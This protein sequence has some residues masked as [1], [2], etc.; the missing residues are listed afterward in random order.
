MDNIINTAKRIFRGTQGTFLG[1]IVLTVFFSLAS[2]YFFQARNF[3]NILEKLSKEHNRKIYPIQTGYSDAGPDLGAD[4]L[5]L[6]KAP[7]IAIFKN[8]NL[9]N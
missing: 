5:K 6:I 1:L 3:I 9:T 8:D 2:P 4:E 7:K